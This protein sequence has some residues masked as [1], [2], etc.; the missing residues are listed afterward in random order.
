M[1]N[2]KGSS[3]APH[4]ASNDSVVTEKLDLLALLVAKARVKPFPSL[5]SGFQ[6]ENSIFTQ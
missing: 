3:D 5:F 4:E 6:R 1:R 2:G